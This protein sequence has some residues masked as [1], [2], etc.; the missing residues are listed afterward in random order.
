MRGPYAEGV[1]NHGGPESCVGVREGVGA[2]SRRAAVALERG[3]S[4][5]YP[6]WVLTSN[7]GRRSGALDAGG[8][9]A[10]KGR[11]PQAVQAR[12]SA[13]VADL[14]D[15]R[16][17]LLTLYYEDKIG[18]DLYAEQEQLLRQQIANAT[19]E[20]RAREAEA[21]QR[22]DVAAQFEAVAAVL[23]LSSMGTRCGGRRPKRNAAFS[24]RSLSTKSQCSR[25]T[26]R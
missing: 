16:R 23:E 21:A 9:H 8:A 11:A 20:A 22:D 24:S 3:I 4:G 2:M 5:A 7:S 18:P 12:G 14:E 6:F 13:V 10:P 25:T 15:R 26:W 17:K 19:A 1:A